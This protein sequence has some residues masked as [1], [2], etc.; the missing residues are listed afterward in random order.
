MDGFLLHVEDLVL[1]HFGV[2]GHKLFIELG[3]RILQVENVALEQFLLAE[4]GVFLSEHVREGQVV[5]QDVQLLRVQV[6]LLVDLI[7]ALNLH[8]ADLFGRE[9]GVGPLGFELAHLLQFLLF[10]LVLA[11]DVELLTCFLRVVAE[12]DVAGGLLGG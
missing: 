8:I 4:G 11:G 6:T 2:S 7:R 9:H 3:A 12:D 5:L 10:D 1:L